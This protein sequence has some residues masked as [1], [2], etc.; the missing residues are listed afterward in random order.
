MRIKEFA[1]GNL[2][3]GV[4]HRSLLFAVELNRLRGGYLFA[5]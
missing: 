2:G 4:E 3:E 1:E 5:L